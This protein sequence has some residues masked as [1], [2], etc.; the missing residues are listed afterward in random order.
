[1]LTAPRLAQRILFG[2]ISIA[3]VLLVIGISALV[4]SSSAL[5]NN[6]SITAFDAPL[7]ENFD[8]L[9]SSGTSPITWT[10]NVTIPGWYATRTT[11]T[12]GTGSSNAG[13]I[14]SFG[15]A[16]TN[17]ISDRAFGSVASGG[18]GT[19]YY[20]VKLTNNTGATIT[21]LDISYIG[22][23]WRN[24]GNVNTNALTFQY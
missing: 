8:S 13:A 6:G 23:Q 20:A 12:V 19:M 14:Y 21:S 2:Y 15:V 24:G 9:A 22:E 18:T 11:Y 4:P 5:T 3:M 1:M 16:G 7:T 10:D 17:P